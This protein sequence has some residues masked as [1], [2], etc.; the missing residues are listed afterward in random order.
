MKL[1]SLTNHFVRH[2][3]TPS[4]FRNLNCIFIRSILIFKSITMKNLI[5]VLFVL[6]YYP[7]LSFRRKMLKEIKWFIKKP[8]MDFTRIRY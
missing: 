4:A 6:S 2:R 1:C 8:K 7:Y 5:S 3:T